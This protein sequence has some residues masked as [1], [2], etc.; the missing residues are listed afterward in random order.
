MIQNGDRAGK[1]VE[2]MKTIVAKLSVDDMLN[3]AA[4]L[5]SLEP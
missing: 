3:M 4:Y 5:G 1:S 2:P